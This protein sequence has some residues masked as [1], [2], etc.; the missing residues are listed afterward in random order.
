MRPKRRGGDDV[1]CCPEGSSGASLVSLLRSL[2]CW[3]SIARCWSETGRNTCP[4]PMVRRRQPYSSALFGYAGRKS[5]WCLVQSRLST[6]SPVHRY[7][8]W[9]LRTHAQCLDAFRVLSDTNRHFRPLCVPRCFSQAV[10]LL[11]F[12]STTAACAS[13]AGSHTW[14]PIAVVA[15]DRLA[16]VLE[17][18]SVIDAGH[19]LHMS[20]TSGCKSDLVDIDKPNGSNQRQQSSRTTSHTNTYTQTIFLPSKYHVLTSA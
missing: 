15:T 20:L 7:A 2:C 19:N 18:Q 12:P 5:R 10:A 13:T 11:L 8:V 9:Y 1:Q 14:R 17:S 4:G 16:V 6:F 3:G